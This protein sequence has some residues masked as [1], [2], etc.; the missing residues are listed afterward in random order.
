[1]T[2][3]KC[4]LSQVAGL[5]FQLNTVWDTFVTTEQLFF[6]TTPIE[7]PTTSIIISLLTLPKYGYLYFALSKYRLRLTDTFTQKD[8]VSKNVKYRLYQKAYSY[9]LDEFFYIVTA[10][11][12][13]NVTGNTTI[14]YVPSKEDAEKVQITLKP[15]SVQEGSKANITLNFLNILSSFTYDLVFNITQ[16][17]MH[18][19]LQVNSKNSAQNGTELFTYQEL[20]SNQLSYIHDDSESQQDTFHFMALSSSSQDL[21]YVDVFYIDILLKNDNSP[22]RT[23]EKIFQVVIEGKKLLTGN[24]LRYSDADIDSKPSAIIYTCHEMPNGKVYNIKNT[25]LEISEFTQESLDN[26]LIVFKHSG[27]HYAVAKLWIT[28]GQFYINGLLEIQALPPFVRVSQNKRLIVQHRKSAVVSEQHLAS[29][30]NLYATD[31]D[32]IYEVVNKP[33]FGKMVSSDLLQV[34]D[35]KRPLA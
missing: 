20:S 21:Q 22:V 26:G 25:T 13:N 3:V 34:C 7:A 27:P 23:I 10:P 17:P 11:G 12:C 33:V 19:T 35:Q 4:S 1:M 24:D 18:G 14:E 16:P 2:F 28:D 30:T 9:V 32:I 8:I 31:G 29:I 15:L 5:S 6:K